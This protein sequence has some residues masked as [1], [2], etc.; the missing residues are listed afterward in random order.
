MRES[1]AAVCSGQLGQRAGIAGK[2]EEPSEK[3]YKGDS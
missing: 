2:A 1:R 3:N